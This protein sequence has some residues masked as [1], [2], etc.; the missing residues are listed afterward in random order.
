M[1]KPYILIISFNHYTPYFKKTNAL[2]ERYI[3]SR[4]ALGGQEFK[5]V[6]SRTYYC[7]IKQ[8]YKLYEPKE[9]SLMTNEK[10]VVS[11]KTVPVVNELSEMVAK[12]NGQSKSE[13]LSM[14]AID[15]AM[16]FERTRHMDTLADF[17]DL[18][19]PYITQDMDEES[20]AKLIE[21]LTTIQ[22]SYCNQRLD[23]HM[24]AQRHLTNIAIRFYLQ[25]YIEEIDGADGFIINQ[26]VKTIY[27]NLLAYGLV[28]RDEW[29]DK[30]SAYDLYM[31]EVGSKLI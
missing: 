27:D 10:R 23:A 6:Y 28:D 22:K 5:K 11:F 3:K 4:L 30:T 1:L 2:G 17:L 26:C 13:F 21:K 14:N 18:A 20:A 31:Q 24:R 15:T 9:A 7:Q 29:F 12:K 16:N 19:L 25:D 8:K